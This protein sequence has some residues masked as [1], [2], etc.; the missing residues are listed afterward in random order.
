MGRVRRLENLLNIIYIYEYYLRKFFNDRF[1]K[2][3][4]QKM[5]PN[6]IIKIADFIVSGGDKNTEKK[7]P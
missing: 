7:I 3:N 2:F 4:I 6:V 5:F 1:N